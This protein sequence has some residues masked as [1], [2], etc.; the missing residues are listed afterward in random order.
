M[1]RIILVLL[2]DVLISGAVSAW[3]YFTQGEEAAL[4]SGLSIFIACSP[5]CL[6]LAEPFTLY[7]TGRQ[8]A[9]LGVTLNNPN[10]LKLVPDINLVALPYNRVLTCNDYYITDLVPDFASP[11]ALL[12]IA[13][14]A[15]RD[16]ENILGRTVY[17]TAISRAF[18]LPKSTDF[19]ELS[20]CGVEAMVDG[21]LIRVGDPRWLESLGTE[22]NTRLR[23][24][25]DQF[26]VKGKTVLVVCTGR[27]ARGLIALKDDFSV[28]AKSFLAELK[29]RNMETLLLTAVPRKMTRR[30]EKEFLL[31]HIRT[32]LT[33]EGKAR[34]V[35][36][37]R[38]KGKVVAVIGTDI[39]DLPAL[40]NAD[41][42]F[43][44]AG[45]SLKTEELDNKPDF[46]LS[47][48]ENFLSI[49][50]LSLKGINA[51]KLNR[52][53]AMASW[54][55]LIPPALLSAFEVLPIPFHPLAAAAGVALFGA[56]I[57]ANS[58]RIKF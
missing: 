3:L 18:R 57:L 20:G 8:L 40:G 49:K 23:T 58:L 42:S 11:N 10:A 51:L 52:R 33:P 43:M 30:I 22:I 17:A 27:V 12:T 19:K 39:N 24:R 29:I 6:V 26:L 32:N 34:E 15:E 41:V 7:L 56:I 38:A 1:R 31:D 54:L 25:I 2:L 9:K 47:T 5:I 37:F 45:G 16:A 44:L 21:R 53:V 55:V 35:Q 46:E 36:I 14:S 50:E 28:D 13:A 4:L 48:L